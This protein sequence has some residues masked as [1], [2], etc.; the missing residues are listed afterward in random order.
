MSE[1]KT[2]EKTVTVMVVK[3]DGSSTI[4]RLACSSTSKRSSRLRKKPSKALSK[5]VFG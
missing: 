5:A 4:K 1:T 3:N 2:S